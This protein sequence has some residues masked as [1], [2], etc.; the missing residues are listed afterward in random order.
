MRPFVIPVAL[1]ALSSTAASQLVCERVNENPSPTF[2][3]FATSWFALKWNSPTPKIVSGAEFYLNSTMATQTV[4]GFFDEDTTTGK[5]N[6]LIAS[7]PIQLPL[8]T[9]SWYGAAFAAPIPVLP[10]TNYFVAVQLGGG[11]QA[12]TWTGG[13]TVTH[14]WSP[15]AWSGPWN[16][17]R[18]MARV[19]CGAN[20]GAFSNY[21]SGKAGSGSFVPA[22]L[23]IGFPNTGNPITIQVNSAL[24]G[25]PAI[26]LWGRRAGITT[27][28]GTIY[29]FPVLATT[30]DVARGS[31]PGRGYL[32]TELV[33]PLDSS[34][35]GAQIAFQ[36]WVPDA[37]ALDSVSHSDGLLMIIGT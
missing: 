8:L 18:W 1:L 20:S 9:P 37:G 12:G 32:N 11:I 17:Q 27:G 2:V 5:P 21:G 25:A 28:I 19:Y 7:T 23:G 29:A 14:Y 35:A 36:T 22:M 24:G 6:N 15:P 31:L 13:Q 3:S 10:N 33:L 34:L 26:L 30:V 16:T 4:I